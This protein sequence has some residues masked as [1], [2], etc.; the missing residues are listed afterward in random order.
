MKKTEL[1]RTQCFIGS[2]IKPSFKVITK[3]GKCSSDVEFPR[4]RFITYEQFAKFAWP[5]IV[6]KALS[7]KEADTTGQI[8]TVTIKPDKMP[9]HYKSSVTTVIENIDYQ[10]EHKNH[11][12]RYIYFQNAN[13]ATKNALNNSELSSRYYISGT[14]EDCQVTFLELIYH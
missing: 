3:D 1:I 4:Y 11:D 13:M 5:E 6:K 10:M 14:S 8:V 7:M 12:V 9:Y 2:S